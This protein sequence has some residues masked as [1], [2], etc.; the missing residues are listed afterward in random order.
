[1]M[2]EATF[3][4]DEDFKEQI[5]AIDGFH[6]KAMWAFLKKPEYWRA[7]SMFLHADTVSIKSWKKRNDLP[8]ISPHVGKEDVEEFAKG[9]SAFFHSMEG[10]GRNCKV[11]VYRRNKKEYFFAYPED[12]G[13]SGIEWISNMLETRASHPAFEIIFVY[14]EEKGSLDIYAPKNNKAVSALQNIFAKTILKLDTLADDPNDPRVYNLQPLADP[15]F[16]FQIDV[17]SKIRSVEITKLRLTLK[18]G[19]KERVTLESDT[20]NNPKAVY[21]LLKKLNFPAFYVS[22]A[23]LKAML[24][25]SYG[26]RAQTKTF[27]ITYPNSCGLNHDGNDLLIRNMLAKSGIEPKALIDSEEDAHNEP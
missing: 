22:Q 4:H 23:R 10:R 19:E 7:A 3:H 9:I 11:E 21:D 13:Q 20:K 25:S 17:G 18:F 14:C 8:N 15:N 12:Y 16:K 26:K 27:N 24:E 6:A 5:A 1:L 2:D